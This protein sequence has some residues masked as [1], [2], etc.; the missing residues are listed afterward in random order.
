M[1]SGTEID[2]ERELTFLAEQREAFQRRYPAEAGRLVPD[3]NRVPDPHLERFIDGFAA[4]AARVH[5]KLDADLPE[6][7]EALAQVFCPHLLRPIP[8]MSM[9]Q[10]EPDAE[11]LPGPGGITFPRHTPLRTRA[12]GNPAIPCRWRTGYPVTVW[13]IEVADARFERGPFA[14]APPRTA[15]ALRLTLAC[16][17]GMKFS[18]LQIDKLRFH[19]SGEKQVVAA[20]YE[21][22]FLSATKVLVRVPGEKK[23]PLEFAPADFL[24]PVG[25][26]LEEAVLPL[27][28]RAFAGYGVLTEFLSFPQKFHFV[29]LAGWD[30]VRNAGL[31]SRI[32]IVVY[33]NRTHENLEQGVHASTFLLGC[34]PIINL[35]EQSAEP[36]AIT[37]TRYEYRVVPARLSPRGVEVF[38]VDDVMGVEEGRQPFPMQPFYSFRLGQ[39]RDDFG[40][41]WHMTRR[42]SPVAGDRGTEVHLFVLDGGWSPHRP[43]N[44]M[45]DVQTTCTNRDFP[46]RFLR[47]GDVLRLERPGEKIGSVTMLV[48]PTPTLRPPRRRALHWRLLSQLGLDHKTLTDPTEGVRMLQESLR[49]CDYSDPE[50]EPLLRAV[51]RQAIEGIASLSSRRVLGRAAS[52]GA[53][54]ICRGLEVTVELNE[55]S[56]VGIGLYLFACVLERYLGWSAGLNSFVK[57]SLRTVQGDAIKTWPPRS[58]GRVLP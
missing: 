36:L 40:A 14:G 7:T 42:D 46:S 47:G 25:F 3:R 32:E 57:M 4:M 41:F 23:P 45:L 51:N 10:F 13:P 16:H 22:L 52:G 54:A 49:L 38:T 48:A 19:L 44:L 18:D 8:S 55:K 31:G 50:I 26:E 24:R 28:D 17:G 21:T 30:S 37:Q 27:V 6:L 35:F 15:A 1:T 43:A 53:L 5:N 34:T 9:A 20:L 2:F 11:H 12:V 39:T 29:D 58:A 33:F 56:Y